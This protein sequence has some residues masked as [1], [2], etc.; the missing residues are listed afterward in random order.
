MPFPFSQGEI[1]SYIQMCTAVGVSLQ[2][3]M[4]YRLRNGS[5]LLMSRRPGAPYDDQVD[6]SGE[7]LVH[8]GHDCPK[9]A[10]TPEPKRVDQPQFNPQGIPTQNGLFAAA[11]QRH[12]VDHEPAEQ[13]RVFD[14][15]RD[16]IWVYNGI[17][18]LIDYWT[19]NS[20]GRKVFKF[21]LK[22]TNLPEETVKTHP[23]QKQEDDRII[24]SWVKQAVWNR[25]QGKCC[26]CDAKSGL[27][28]DHII[29]YS[30]GGSSK[31]P[32][33]IQIL[34]VRH[35]LAKHDHIE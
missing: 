2:R 22:L 23:S 25:D 3:G 11:A 8:E 16:G 35:N 30:K 15:I 17:F 33:N 28:F 34:C 7:I 14:K 12:T 6:E 24:P 10:E 32:K 1:I 19:D 9:S 29:P 13:V 21:K 26:V 5:V 27:H 31:D 18:K 20:K 4:N